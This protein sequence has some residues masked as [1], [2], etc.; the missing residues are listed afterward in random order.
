MAGPRRPA[1]R[2][3]GDRLAPERRPDRTVRRGRGR[4]RDRPPAASLRRPASAWSWPCR[5]RP[6]SCGPSWTGCGNSPAG[7]PPRGRP[8][9]RAPA[10][11]A[12][13]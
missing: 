13:V 12:G 4:D 9:N 5:R 6:A 1:Q 2:A 7:S 10:P 8:G 11:A 3:A